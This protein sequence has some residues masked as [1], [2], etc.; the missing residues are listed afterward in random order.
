VKWF[1]AQREE[2]PAAWHGGKVG[3]GVER[4]ATNGD[5]MMLLGVAVQR[6]RINQAGFML[7]ISLCQVYN[8]SCCPEVAICD[9]IGDAHTTTN[10]VP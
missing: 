6:I 4:K 5:A 7:C 1:K 2:R 3:G 9:D 8:Q 10:E